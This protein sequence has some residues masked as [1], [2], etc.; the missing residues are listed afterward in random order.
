MLACADDFP[1]PELQVV[2]CTLAR[3]LLLCCFVGRYLLLQVR[4]CTSGSIYAYRT[5]PEVWCPCL[6]PHTCFVDLLE[7]G[8]ISPQ[9]RQARIHSKQSTNKTSK[10]VKQGRTCS[11]VHATHTCFGHLSTI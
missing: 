9:S 8:N 6:V 2:I 5:L 1:A 11:F 10:Q 7:R 4:G 3:G